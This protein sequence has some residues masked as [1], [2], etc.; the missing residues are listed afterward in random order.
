MYY[1]VTFTIYW[2]GMF[3][4]L[5]AMVLILRTW[6]CFHQPNAGT[7]YYTTCQHAALYSI[8]SFPNLIFKPFEIVLHVMSMTELNTLLPAKRYCIFITSL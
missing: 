7:V 6:T 4:S 2:Q 5:V 3:H 8:E 1:E